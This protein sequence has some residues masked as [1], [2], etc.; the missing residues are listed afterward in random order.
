MDEPPC[1]VCDHPAQFV[2]RYGEKKRFACSW[3]CAK[4]IN[5]QV[6]KALGWCLLY[7]MGRRP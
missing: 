7:P 5:T 3:N 4:N 6:G 2:A 1:N